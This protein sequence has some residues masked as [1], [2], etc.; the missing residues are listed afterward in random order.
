MAEPQNLVPNLSEI[1]KEY[2]TSEKEVHL[3]LSG[4]NCLNALL[5]ILMLMKLLFIIELRI[6]VAI[7]VVTSLN[8]VIGPKCG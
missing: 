8:Y 1:M 2:T 6:S 3:E 7:N 5:S 4:A